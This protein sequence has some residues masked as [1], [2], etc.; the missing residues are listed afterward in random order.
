MYNVKSLWFLCHSLYPC[1]LICLI[2]VSFL[3]YRAASLL[4]FYDGFDGFMTGSP[5]PFEPFVSPF[6]LEETNCLFC[7]FNAP[8]PYGPFCPS[9][10][11]DGTFGAFMARLK[12]VPI[13]A[14]MSP[15]WPKWPLYG[16]F[17]SGFS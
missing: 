6:L 15:L 7:P 8:F 16:P 4:P 2:N 13:V 11:Y 12:N 14:F 3:R 9:T 10:P 1:C 17:V 5:E